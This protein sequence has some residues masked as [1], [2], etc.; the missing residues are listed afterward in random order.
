MGA[1]TVV[2]GAAGVAEDPDGIIDSSGVRLALSETKLGN[3]TPK[4]TRAAL[5]CAG[6]LVGLVEAIGALYGAGDCRA[7]RII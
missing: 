3:E 5:D 1:L 6:A 4:G 7:W 2:E